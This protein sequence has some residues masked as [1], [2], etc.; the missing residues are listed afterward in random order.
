M[1]SHPPELP[2]PPRFRWL[3]FLALLLAPAVLTS[4][5]IL[6]DK[7]SNGPAPAVGLIA[8]AIGGIACGVLLG[9]HM[10]QTT[11]TKVILSFVFTAICGVACITIATFGCISSGYSLNVH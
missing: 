11:A 8:G 4:L 3:L 10:G 2:R 1:D 5:S 9:C 6:L 7:S